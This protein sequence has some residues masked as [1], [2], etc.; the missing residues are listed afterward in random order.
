MTSIL[1]AMFL[2]IY[3]IN[4]TLVVL[5]KNSRSFIIAIS[6]SSNGLE[7]MINVAK[8]QFKSLLYLSFLSLALFMAIINSPLMVFAD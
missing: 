1:M 5:D 7:Y 8:Y 6:R 4:S 2:N 3:Q